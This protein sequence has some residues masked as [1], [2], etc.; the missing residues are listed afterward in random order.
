[1]SISSDE[2]SF[3]IQRYF[4]ESG[5]DHS[6]YTFNTESQ[7][8]L[9]AI[10]GSQIPPGA[11]I[12]LL[13]KGLLY[14][15]LEKEIHSANRGGTA[16]IGSQLTLLDAALREGA[17][18]PQKPEKPIVA[19]TNS[20]T[21]QLDQSNSHL[22]L[23]DGSKAVCCAWSYDNRYLAA[24]SSDNTA[25]IWDLR[26]VQSPASLVLHHDV[27]GQKCE[28]SSLDWSADSS[29]LVTGCSNGYCHLWDIT[30][31]ERLSMTDSTAAV[32]VA[33]HVVRFDPSGQRF[34]SGDASS[35]LVVRDT[36]GTVLRRENLHHGPIVDASWKT[37]LT[38]AL[39]C[40]D[41]TV[42]IVTGD[43]PTRELLGH[44]GQVNGIA[45]SASG[46][47]LAS[48]CDDKTVRLWHEGEPVVL[49]GHTQSVYA[50]KWSVND[51]LASSSFDH[52]IR[53]WD[54]RAA[55]C[56]QTLLGH[57]GTIYGMCF[58]HE[59]AILASGG[60]DQTIKFWRVSDGNLVVTFV[61]P[62]ALYDLQR[63]REGKY[64]AACCDGGDVV[65][66]QTAALPPQPE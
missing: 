42:V 57:T 12:T 61:V 32:Q 7:T 45:W 41:G 60:Q 33:I 30:G 11:L 27:A 18:L 1:M 38:F 20:P 52:T 23:G 37:E 21:L 6:L 8:D 10:N 66:V 56:L 50:I 3:L 5:F 19:P 15:Q 22:L 4:Y 59:G 55:Q 9:T 58:T 48:C 35:V 65:L 46:E 47:F 49:L 16:F 2:I 36:E 29:L 39:S 44:T 14:I 34:L 62:Q 40:D 28:I 63:D 13:Q 25:I 64:V 54:P 31:V 53:I 51:I 17:S 26:D 43:E 24:G